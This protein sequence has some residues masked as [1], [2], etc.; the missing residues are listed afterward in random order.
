VPELLK[1]TGVRLCGDEE[2]VPQLKSACAAITE[3]SSAAIIAALLGLPL[4]LARYGNLRQQEY[5]EILAAYP[6]AM[7]LDSLDSFS[8]SM[9]NL[10]KAT[11]D[12]SARE[13][14]SANAGPMPAEMMPERVA[15]IVAMV[16][17]RSA[18]PS[19]LGNARGCDDG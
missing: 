17:S 4:F 19:N 8:G 3:P 12:L 9:R 6:R 1:K 2:F 7:P 15:D 10:S 16:G 18:C 11:A 13:W 14:I 5:G